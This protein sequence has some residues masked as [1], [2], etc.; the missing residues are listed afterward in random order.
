MTRD[1]PPDPRQLYASVG[2]GQP[3]V[4]ALDLDQELAIVVGKGRRPRA[5]PFGRKTGQSIDRFRRLAGWRSRRTLSRYGPAPADERAREADRRRAPRRSPLTA[6]RRR[7]A[8]R[9]LDDFRASASTAPRSAASWAST[10]GDADPS[11]VAIPG[12]RCVRSPPPCAGTSPGSRRTWNRAFQGGRPGDEAGGRREPADGDDVLTARKLPDVV[13]RGP[14][15]VGHAQSEGEGNWS[16]RRAVSARRR[17]S[18]WRGSVRRRSPRGR[19]GHPARSTSKGCRRSCSPREAY[20]GHGVPCHRSASSRPITAS[21]AG[22]VL[23]AGERRRRACRGLPGSARGPRHRSSPE[24]GRASP[25][26]AR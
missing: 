21:R 8:P 18:L 12:G 5:S 26:S 10:T 14:L 17:T 15:P 22:A 2:G 16:R 3:A 23:S 6:L 9:A 24:H 19:E 1:G 4:E 20:L 13:A 7:S 11:G 25:P